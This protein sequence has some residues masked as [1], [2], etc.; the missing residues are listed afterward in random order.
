MHINSIKILADEY[1]VP[2]QQMMVVIA[3]IEAT[4]AYWNSYYSSSD[5]DIKGILDRVFGDSDS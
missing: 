3:T 2:L 4:E 5:E 1:E